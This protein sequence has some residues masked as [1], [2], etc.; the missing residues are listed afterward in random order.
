M[1]AV[2]KAYEAGIDINIEGLFTG[3]SRR[4][5]AIPS[6]AFQ[7]ERY[8]I[9]EPRRKRAS[10][11]HPLLGA[12]QESARGEVIFETEVF[13]T[14]P[15]WLDDHRVYGRVVMPGAV[16]GAMAASISQSEG[17]D[18]VEV[19]ELQLHTAMVFPEDD[20]DSDNEESGRRVQLV[21]DKADD[22]SPQHFEI[23]SKS[24]SEDEWTLHAEGLLP[25]TANITRSSEPINL[26]ALKSRLQAQD[27]GEFYQQKAD[28]GINF[29]TTFKS[30]DTLWAGAGE[31]IGEVVLNDSLQDGTLEAHPVLIDGC[32]QVLSAARESMQSTGGTTYLPFAWEK[33][34]FAE[35]LPPK[36]VCHA[37]IND[38]ASINE[39]PDD[40]D[41]APEALTGQIHIY[42]PDGEQI[43]GHRRI[44]SQT[45]H[46]RIAYTC[47]R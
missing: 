33:M 14:D 6:Y 35:Q 28:S 31:S 45:S 29:G 15:T 11:D 36:V 9:E 17:A 20:A 10:S 5:I 25:Q 47:E 46:P 8:W 32:F 13:P 39:N 19:N 23:F 42:T 21:L 34:W 26:S 18:A 43:G 1:T 16:Y 27:T 3:E 38:H 7:R 22:D 44:R 40:L 12:K 2:A 30:V 4:R 37:R 24:E 41:S